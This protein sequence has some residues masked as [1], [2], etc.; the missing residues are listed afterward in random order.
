MNLRPGRPEDPLLDIVFV[1]PY[2]TREYCARWCNEQDNRL[3]RFSKTSVGILSASII[4]VTCIGMSAFSL[5]NATNSG[6]AG[7]DSA[8]MPASAAAMPLPAAAVPSA[9][10]QDF[11]QSGNRT[12]SA[13][14]SSTPAVCAYT[15]YVTAS[16]GSM[17]TVGQ[18]AS[19]SGQ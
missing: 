2:P 6:F 16:C 3:F 4:L 14:S 15:P 12:L 13:P 18:G 11:S 5:S 17:L 10:N 1:P 9:P 19:G 7:D 8:M